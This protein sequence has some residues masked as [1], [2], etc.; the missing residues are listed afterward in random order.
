VRPVVEPDFQPGGSARDRAVRTPQELGHVIRAMERVLACHDSVP[1]PVPKLAWHCFSRRVSYMTQMVNRP[2]A[3]LGRE[4]GA[5]PFLVVLPFPVRSK[6]L[7]AS[8]GSH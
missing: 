2:A 7:G 1:L 5:G 4:V 3:I 6:R 8:L